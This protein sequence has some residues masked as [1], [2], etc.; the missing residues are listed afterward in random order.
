MEINAC[1]H[2]NTEGEKCLRNGGSMKKNIC[3]LLCEIS[4]LPLCVAAFAKS[5]VALYI[6]VR[7]LSSV[8][9]WDER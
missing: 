3:F 6:F 4:G 1:T 9:N 2:T 5:A 7:M 8:G